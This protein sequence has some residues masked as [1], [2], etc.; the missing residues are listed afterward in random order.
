LGCLFS[1]F[2]FFVLVPSLV[3]RVCFLSFFL[4]AQ[5]E[6]KNFTTKQA[7]EF[8]NQAVARHD[9]KE[10]PFHAE[11]TRSASKHDLFTTSKTLKKKSW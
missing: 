4:W 6:E 2:L 11:V 1:F 3:W 5:R 8:H 7:K 10:S 9:S